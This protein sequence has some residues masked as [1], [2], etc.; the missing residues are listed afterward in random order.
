MW[1]GRPS[2]VAAPLWP[3]PVSLPPVA[4]SVSVV[5]PLPLVSVSVVVWL[6]PVL[7]SVSVVVP[8]PPVSLLPYRK[9]IA[10]DDVSDAEAATS[11]TAEAP[12]RARATTETTSNRIAE[13][14]RCI[15][16]CSFILSCL[17]DQTAAMQR[18]R[19]SPGVV[20]VRPCY[21]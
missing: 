11:P 20:A 8:L 2:V 6:P 13:K 4:V 21:A 5:V 18:N 15:R 19:A 12:T 10:S 9:A 7:V 14:R 3:P 16:P 17:S 1:A